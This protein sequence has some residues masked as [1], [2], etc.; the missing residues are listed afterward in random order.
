MPVPSSFP[1]PPLFL[2]VGSGSRA[3]SIAY[4]ASSGAEPS[5]LWLGGFASD[6]KGT[7]AERLSAMAER[8]GWGFCRFD[9][10]G[11]GE[12]GGAFVEGTISRWREEA[13]AVLDATQ[14]GPVILVGS[15]MGAWIALRLIAELRSLG[16]G[17]RIVG[18]LLLAPAPDF[19]RRLVV[20]K[21]SPAQR[22]DLEANGFCSEPSQYGAPTI[23]SRALIEDGEENL[24]MENPIETGCPVHII[25]G[26]EDRDVPYSHA[27]DLVTLLP[28]DGVTL[29]LVRD[30]DHRL[31]RESDILRMEQAI[32]GLVTEARQRA[33]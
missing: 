7:K 2:D 29:T 30:G 18:L 26:M 11:H 33:G 5:L 6:M 21:L 31:S 28:A 12:S 24:V 19:T 10:S 1:V 23:Y 27:L 4:R 14:A 13:Q 16:R 3:R 17:E 9:Y 8:E 20:P 22:G 15:S 25:Q 32:G